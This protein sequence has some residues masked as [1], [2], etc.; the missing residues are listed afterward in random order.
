MPSLIPSSCFDF[1]APRLAEAF[2]NELVILQHHRR[3]QRLPKGQSVLFATGPVIHVLGLWLS[4]AVF[5]CVKWRWCVE[6]RDRQ[7]CFTIP[8]FQEQRCSTSSL[9]NLVPQQVLWIC[10]SSELL[11]G[12]RTWLDLHANQNVQHWFT[13]CWLISNLKSWGLPRGKDSRDLSCVL[14]AVVS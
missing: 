9:S 2:K 3:N 7:T 8:V 14:S 5:F 4:S 13:A 6:W 1:C 11:S 10:L 12:W